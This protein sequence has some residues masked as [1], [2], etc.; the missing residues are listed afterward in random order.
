[1]LHIPAACCI[2][3]T[4]ACGLLYWSA[5]STVHAL[6]WKAC[7]HKPGQQASPIGVNRRLGQKEGVLRGVAPSVAA[8]AAGGCVGVS[9]SMAAGAAA[10]AGG[11]ESAGVSA[12]GLP[13]PSAAALF[14]QLLSSSSSSCTSCSAAAAA[15]VVVAAGVVSLLPSSQ[16]MGAT[17]AS[18]PISWPRL[19]RL[20]WGVW[21]AV[22]RVGVSRSAEA[23]HV[24]AASACSGSWPL[25]CCCGSGV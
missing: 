11:G 17:C 1:M 22:E 8:A 6:R 16:L 24:A 2:V 19:L 18:V 5:D 10:A 9:S 21:P 3:F 20:T 4:T 14:R 15:A 13:L 12:C 7:L 23:P 25:P